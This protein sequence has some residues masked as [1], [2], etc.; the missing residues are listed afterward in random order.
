M[1]IEI[2]WDFLRKINKQVLPN[3]KGVKFLTERLKNGKRLVLLRFGDGEY[4]LMKQQDIALQKADPKLATKL[5][6]AMKNKEAIIG[7]PRLKKDSAYRNMEHT[8]WPGAIYFYFSKLK[9]RKNLIT[10][11]VVDH[12]FRRDHIFLRELFKPGSRILWIA[13]Q[14][15]SF[16]NCFGRAKNIQF[17]FISAPPK[18]AWRKKG[19]IFSKVEEQL[20]KNEF[21]S[22]LFSLGTTAVVLV[23][24][25]SRKYPNLESNILDIGSF[26]NFVSQDFGTCWHSWMVKSYR[27]HANKFLEHI[28]AR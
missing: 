7:I 26:A 8:V 23:D 21:D 19:W 11:S 2:D 16:K 3:P 25:L 10:A 9:G 15:K 6:L 24:E 22:I 4:L 14:A 27:G 28:G 17:K 1:G 12:D 18:N 13:G 5:R 20:S